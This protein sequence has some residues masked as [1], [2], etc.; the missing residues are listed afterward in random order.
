MHDSAH[1]LTACYRVVTPMFLSGADPNDAELRLPSFKSALRFW[2]RALAAS[3]FKGDIKTLREA[4]DKLFG[5]TRSGQSRVCIRLIDSDI[6]KRTQCKF[7]PNSWQSYVG[8]GLIGKKDQNTRKCIDAGSTFRVG[9]DA[10]R[11]SEE[12]LQELCAALILLGLAGGLGSRSRKGWGSLTL[13]S[14]EGSEMDPIQLESLN[15]ELKMYFS[16]EQPSMLP[17]WTAVSSQCRYAVGPAQKNPEAAHEW[18]AEK[19][20]DVLRRTDKSRR[21]AFGLPRKGIGDQNHN[22]RRASPIFLH[23]HQ[24]LKGPAFPVAIFLPAIF[25]EGQPKPRGGW[26]TAQR[27]IECLD[28]GADS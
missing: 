12:Q 17:S 13:L 6:Q 26:E 22:S 14:L 19:Y 21:E 1:I 3:R 10:T 8:Y 27:F 24:G 9:M 28:Q 11:C 23:V 7:K 15:E 20:R 25:L 2:W 4:E 5:S 16:V 18:L